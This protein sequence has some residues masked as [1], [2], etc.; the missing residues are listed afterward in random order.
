M[1]LSRAR[2]L[3]RIA[4][5]TRFPA[6][7]WAGAAG[8]AAGMGLIFTHWRPWSDYWFACVWFGYIGLV[9]AAVAQRDGRSLI[10]SR[11]RLFLWLLPLSAAGWWFFEAANLFVQNWHYLQPLDIPDWWKQIWSAVFFSPVIPAELETALLLWPSGVVQRVSSAGPRL[12]ASRRTAALLPL[13]GLGNLLLA[14]LYPQYA[15]PLL[16]GCLA[17]ILDPLNYR[18]G[19]PSILGAWARGDWRVPVVLA[20]GGTFCG[21]LWEAWNYWAFPKWWYTV[22]WVGFAKV[23]EMPLL[24]Y[25]GYWAFAWEV[26]AL[27]HFVRPRLPGLGPAPDAAAQAAA[28]AGEGLTGLGL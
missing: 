26:Y 6:Y 13:L 9:D 15:F 17:L 2:G 5:T 16:W 28:G 23:F 24:G 11:P 12:T 7:G 8:I 4:V 3:P 21:L 14:V 25:L 22:P 19:R 10:R 1:L 20:L 27:V 18:A